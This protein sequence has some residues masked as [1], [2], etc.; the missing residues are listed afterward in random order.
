MDNVATEVLKKGVI[1]LAGPVAR[2]CNVSMATGVIPDLFKNTIIHHVYKGNGINP[3]DPGSSRP[4]AILPS[5]S[6]VLEIAVC[7]SL[8][9][10][11]EEIGF[12][13]EN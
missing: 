10:W 8:L 13:P 6:K 2:L 1:T 3:R 12:L 4:V 5:L 7:D 11:F 9:P